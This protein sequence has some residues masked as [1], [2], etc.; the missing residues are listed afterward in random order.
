MRKGK[1]Q[2]VYRF[3]KKKRNV[4]RL[5]LKESREVFFCFVFSERQGKVIPC[6]G[7]EDRNVWGTDSGKSDTRG[8]K[9]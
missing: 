8:L 3:G 7:T 1:T 9:G 5:D 4:L 2:R 6:R